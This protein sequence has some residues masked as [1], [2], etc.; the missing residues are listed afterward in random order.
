MV[1]HTG[2]LNWQVVGE[3]SDA[4]ADGAYH[5]Y[6]IDLSGIDMSQGLLVGFYSLLAPATDA[7]HI[8]DVELA[9]AEP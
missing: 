6:D 7:W 2:G 3:L 4:D 9:R 8:D 5:L 1:S